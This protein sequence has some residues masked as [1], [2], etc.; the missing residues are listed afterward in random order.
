MNCSLLYSSGQLEIP[1]CKQRT[2][3]TT[4][5]PNLS[6]GSKLSVQE[7]F[8]PTRVIRHYCTVDLVVP[9][10][11]FLPIDIPSWSSKVPRPQAPSETNLI[12][13]SF[14]ERTC[15]IV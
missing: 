4:Q 7:L 8:L 12:L 1:A 10:F 14:E 13:R 2:T 5:G 15:V 6:A 3:F 9:W 11:C